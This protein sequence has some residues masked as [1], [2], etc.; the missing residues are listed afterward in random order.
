L[1]ERTINGYGFKIVPREAMPRLMAK[2]S[3]KWLLELK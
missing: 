2:E 3:L 1:H